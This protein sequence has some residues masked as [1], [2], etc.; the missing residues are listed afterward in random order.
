MP[1]KWNNPDGSRMKCRRG[2][3]SD[4]LTQGLC[5]KCYNYLYYRSIT[6]GRKR[7]SRRDLGS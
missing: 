3:G 7:N 1:S 2:C 4:V 6:P 5:R